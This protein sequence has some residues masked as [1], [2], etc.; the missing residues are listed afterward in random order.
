MLSLMLRYFV[1]VAQEGSVRQAAARLNIAASAVNRHILECESQMGCAL[2]ERM[3]RGMRLTES[4]KVLYEACSRM[5]RE[6][7]NALSELELIRDAK[8]GHVTVGT[9][10]LLAEDFFPPLI[11]RLLVRYPGITYSFVTGTS[12]EIAAQ[13][14]QD[15]VDLGMTWEP[16][17]GTAVRR[18]HSARV[19]FGVAFRKGHPLGK[20]A[21]IHL[22]DCRAYPVAHPAAGELRDVLHRLNLAG[23]NRT[24]AAVQTASIGMLRS[25]VCRGDAVAITSMVTVW[26][27]MIDGQVEFRRIKGHTALSTLLSLYV[28]QDR[29]LPRA[30]ALMADEV[31][32]SFP[33]Y[34]AAQGRRE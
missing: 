8:H 13:V 6:Y 30:V 29:T 23:E 5:N 17:Q 16:M 21:D 31:A 7:E 18:L 14:V 26:Q 11:G 1:A 20:R 32:Q 19:P 12:A 2:F 3:P 25:L 33:N 10:Q 9:L 22:Q 27:A 15:E 28:R 4:G 24:T 34:A